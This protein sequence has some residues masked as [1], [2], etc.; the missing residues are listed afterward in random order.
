MFQRVKAKLKSPIHVVMLANAL[1]GTTASGEASTPKSTELHCS[2]VSLDGHSADAFISIDD[3]D[4]ITFTF[5]GSSVQNTVPLEGHSHSPNVG[6]AS[7]MDGKGVYTLVIHRKFFRPFS[8]GF[9]PTNPPATL[10]IQHADE[11]VVPMVDVFSG[12]CRI[13]LL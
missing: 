7:N 10:T 8:E 12:N 1:M 2:L 6:F 5:N 11:D 4:K 13:E 3:D 9:D